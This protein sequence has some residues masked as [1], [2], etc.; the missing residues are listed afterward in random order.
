MGTILLRYPPNWRTL[1]GF[2]SLRE[3]GR[4]S[5]YVSY[6][7]AAQV[8]QYRAYGVIVHVR[9]EDKSPINQTDAGADSGTDLASATGTSGQGFLM[10]S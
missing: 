3:K 4:I 6:T 8:K 10:A 9:T 5:F 7:N 2:L 1:E